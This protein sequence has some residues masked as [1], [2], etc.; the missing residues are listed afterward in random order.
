MV[1]DDDISDD[2]D[3]DVPKL[4]N[5]YNEALLRQLEGGEYEDEVKEPK[6]EK[7]L[8][9]IKNPEGT[10]VLFFTSGMRDMGLIW[11]V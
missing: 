5:M 9:F 4:P 2:D 1:D 3:D 7:A 6:D 11:Y 10:I 8:Q